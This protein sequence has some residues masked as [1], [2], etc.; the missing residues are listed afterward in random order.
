MRRNEFLDVEQIV[1]WCQRLLQAK[2]KI[3]SWYE[4]AMQRPWMINWGNDVMHARMRVCL[5]I[6]PPMTSHS[7]DSTHAKSGQSV[8]L[9]ALVSVGIGEYSFTSTPLVTRLQILVAWSSHATDNISMKSLH[10]HRYLLPQ[11]SCPFLPESHF[12]SVNYIFCRLCRLCYFTLY[13]DKLC[14]ALQFSLRIKFTV[15][16]TFTCKNVRYCK[17]NKMMDYLYKLKK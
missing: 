16:Q 5:R 13:C 8:I 1:R 11:T 6:S 2:N 4:W 17:M 7:T 10:A 3:Q 9:N 12:L 15:A 14:N